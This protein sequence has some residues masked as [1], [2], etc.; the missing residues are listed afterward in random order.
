MTIDL[1]LA[2]HL[3]ARLHEIGFD[4]RGMTRASYDTGENQAH[5][6]LAATA[7]EIGLEVHTD[8]AANLFI[9]L[10]GEDRTAPVV[11][12]GSHVDTVPLGGNF[13]GAAG[14]LA[15]LATLSGWRNEGYRPRCDVTVVV[16]RAE[17]SAWF[18]VS[19][20]GSKAAFGVLD[21]ASLHV[22]QRGSGRTL[23]E[24]MRQSGGQPDQMGQA[25]VLHAAQIACFVELHIEQGPVLIGTDTTLGIV[26]GICGSLRYRT[27][28]IEGDYAHSG[29]TP[30]AFRR[31]AVLAMSAFITQ[32]QQCWLAIEA[33]G[34]DMTLTFGVCHTDADQADFSTVAGKVTLS[35]DVRS[36]DTAL[37]T[38]MDGH[39]QAARATVEAEY[40]VRVTLGAVTGS[41]P[42]NMDTALQSELTQAAHRHGVAVRSMPSGA[43][44][45]AAIF[46][47]QG[48]PTAM[49][50][51]RNA[52]GSHNP[53]EAMDEADFAV[54]A[55]VLA[56]VLEARSR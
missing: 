50:F 49:L 22:R 19:Y 46:S 27:I 13:D 55:E 11:M 10:P 17:E 24:H 34:G 21:V 42:A 1:A 36:R 51:V 44:H 28:T 30:R 4:G 31:D 15:G 33:E 20:I 54:G 56:T 14:V 23:F 18:P 52:N 37:L 43:G 25:R 7:R 53:D 48:V 41:Q 35:L 2:R 47:N 29:A 8:W 12:T 32:L 5:S 3:F 6:L 45:D 38:Q 9:T 26:S 39:I 40:G 16:I